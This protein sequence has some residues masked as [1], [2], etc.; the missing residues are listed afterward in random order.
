[1]LGSPAL[2]MK[3]SMHPKELQ[4]CSSIGATKGHQKRNC[5]KQYVTMR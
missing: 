3:A 2:S 1:M 5:R 4:P